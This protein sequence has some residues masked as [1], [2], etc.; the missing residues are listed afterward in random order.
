MEKEYQY[1]KHLR[2]PKK[3]LAAMMLLYLLGYS[4]FSAILLLNSDQTVNL[5]STIIVFLVIGVIMTAIISLEFIVIY[6]AVFRRFKK[7]NVRLAEDS[8]IYNNVKRKQEIQYSEIT[9][10]KFPSIKY[11]GGWLNIKY[12]SG[13]IKLTVVL[14]NIGDL[15]KTLKNKID[16][17]GKS[18]IYNEKKIF[19]FYKTAQFSDHSWAR[20]YEYWKMFILFIIINATVGFLISFLI[21]SSLLKGLLT[22]SAVFL[23]VVLYLVSEIIFAV[24]LAKGS[25]A[26]KFYV[27]ERDKDF[28]NKV[29]K[30]GAVIYSIV[31]L[32]LA[33]A[34]TII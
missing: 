32:I 25:D 27:P 22:V 6:Y 18:G 1:R 11:L 9:A 29:F 3:F 34:L 14:E 33:V 8:I 10:L 24:K 12:K 5:K 13:S 15:L 7:V 30:Q 17:E 20:L 31:Y 19:K 26:E 16:A 23:P 4:V 21:K 2:E 28:E